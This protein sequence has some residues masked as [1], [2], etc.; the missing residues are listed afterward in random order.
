MV[1]LFCR[2]KA[3]H[4]RSFSRSSA[5]APSHWLLDYRAFEEHFI[6]WATREM[7]LPNGTVINVDGK[8]LRGSATKKE[9]Q[10][11]HSQGGKSAVHLVQAAEDY[12]NAIIGKI[13]EARFRKI[14][15]KSSE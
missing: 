9:R 11:P 5:A 10:T 8:K 7:K 3:K 13:G 1:V 4:S 2:R 15:D 14:L 6:G 12:L